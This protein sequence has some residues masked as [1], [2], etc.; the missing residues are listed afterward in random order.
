MVPATA[1]TARVEA[2]CAASAGRLPVFPFL[3]SV[4]GRVGDQ[5][6]VHAVTAIAS[7]TATVGTATATVES[8]RKGVTE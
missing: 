1:A 8:S 6:A 5:G 3:S 7:S 2:V 4:G